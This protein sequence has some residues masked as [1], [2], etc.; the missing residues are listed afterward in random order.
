MKQGSQ[1]KT[2]MCVR[3]HT[4]THIQ[5]RAQRSGAAKLEEGPQE[6]STSVG[7]FEDQ[8]GPGGVPHLKSLQVC[9]PPTRKFA[10]ALCDSGLLLHL[11]RDTETT[12]TWPGGLYD[13]MRWMGTIKQKTALYSSRPK[14]Q[15]V[16]TGCGV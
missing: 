6:K 10:F 8:G 5:N 9:L 3:A 14:A 4:C 13:P 11:V 15:M 2:Y 7:R 12:H 16:N 1:S